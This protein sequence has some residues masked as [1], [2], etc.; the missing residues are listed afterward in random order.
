MQRG[1]LGRADAWAVAPSVGPRP[2]HGRGRAYNLRGGGNSA[3]ATRSKGSAASPR[4]S[5]RRPGDN[6]LYDGPHK[7][8]NNVGTGWLRYPKSF[9][10]VADWYKALGPGKA[11][12]HVLS[13]RC[14]GRI[15]NPGQERRPRW[16]NDGWGEL[17]ENGGRN[18]AAKEHTL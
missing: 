5:N 15:V 7:W 16:G 9:W 17:L 18:F 12:R 11:R 10:V 6:G 2:V 4:A 1:Y 8:G 14:P 3:A 13:T